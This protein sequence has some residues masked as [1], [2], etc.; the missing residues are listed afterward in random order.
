MRVRGWTFVLAV[1]VSFG[2][3]SCAQTG[4]YPMSA[5]PPTSTQV[6]SVAV[7]QPVTAIVLYLT[8][9]PGDTIELLDAE[10]LGSTDGAVIKYLVSRPVLSASGDHVIGEVFEPLQGAV[11]AT[12]RDA[13]TPSLAVGD[14]I[15]GESVGIAI[16]LMAVLP[17]RYRIDSIRLRYRL[18]GGSE[19]VGDGGDVIW[20]VCADDPAPAECPET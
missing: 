8:A 14:V 12:E 13:G 17:G 16:E 1:T 10:A 3:V 19:Q 15:E 2:A 11:I 6:N 20:T 9:Q 18:N 5:D 4:S 7:G